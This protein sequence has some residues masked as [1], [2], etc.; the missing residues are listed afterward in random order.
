MNYDPVV[1]KCHEGNKKLCISSSSR[2]ST[3]KH[4]RVVKKRT[5]SHLISHMTLFSSGLVRSHDI[6]TT[7]DFPCHKMYGIK[8]AQFFS[9]FDLQKEH[10]VEVPFSNLKSI[11]SAY[12]ILCKTL[13]W[14]TIH[15]F[16][17]KV[18]LRIRKY[19]FS[20]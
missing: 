2:P 8:G 7:L 12:R 13:Y 4:G 15:A 18:M 19:S 17:S 14:S 6:L 20:S 1:T 16:V 3:N 5:G 9:S 10:R 11:L